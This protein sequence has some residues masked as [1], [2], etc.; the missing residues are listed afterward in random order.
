MEVS[1]AVAI[2]WTDMSARD[3]RVAAT[4]TADAKAV[5]RMLALALVMGGVDRRT[6]AEACGGMDRQSLRGEED[7]ETVH[8]GLLKTSA[9]AGAGAA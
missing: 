9:Q 6:S 1:I 8:W 7:E 4:K 3:L 5:R 2:T